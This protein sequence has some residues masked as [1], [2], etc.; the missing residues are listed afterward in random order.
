MDS[1]ILKWLYLVK[2]N[3]DLLWIKLNN[4]LESK[5]LIAF[6]KYFLDTEQW[7]KSLKDYSWY[8][9]EDAEDDKQK[10]Y[11]K[12]SSNV[13]WFWEIKTNIIN[14]SF[15]QISSSSGFKDIDIADITSWLIHI[16][17]MEW[18][19][20]KDILLFQSFNKPTMYVWE[21]FWSSKFSFALYDQSRVF[22]ELESDKILNLKK[23]IDVVHIFDDDKVYINSKYKYNIIFNF[24]EEFKKAIPIIFKRDFQDNTSIFSC[25]STAMPELILSIQENQTILRKVYITVH[26]KLLDWFD[27]V[28]FKSHI[29]SQWLSAIEFDSDDK[30]VLKKP[31][32]NDLIDAININFFTGW[33]WENY[34]SR[35]KRKR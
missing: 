21:S 5:F 2:G 23:T 22:K 35:Q 10:N 15:T 6:E 9:V 25:D 7:V 1:I 29:D 14:W 19:N 27:L 20:K 16:E 12:N 30:I 17:G 11:Y 13:P 8:V 33:D 3:H 34:V 24:Y 32:F 31:G 28:V 4:T 18:S 26:N